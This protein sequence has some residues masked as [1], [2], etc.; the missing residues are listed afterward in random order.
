MTNVRPSFMRASLYSVIYSAEPKYLG[1]A[2]GVR[3]PVF[4]RTNIDLPTVPLCSNL[5]YPLAARLP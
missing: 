5:Y 1:N 3:I 2:L 4:A